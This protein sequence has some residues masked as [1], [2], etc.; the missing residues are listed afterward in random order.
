MKGQ[1]RGAHTDRHPT[2][3]LSEERAILGGPGRVPER[4]PDKRHKQE[5]LL[6]RCGEREAF[7]IDFSVLLEWT[8][9]EALSPGSLS[10]LA[11]PARME[12]SC[13]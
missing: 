8:A 1:D 2:L 10:V 5:C 11:P 7:Y 9:G 4:E 12:S 3:A 6:S 13:T